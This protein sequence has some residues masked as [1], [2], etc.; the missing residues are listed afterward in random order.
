MVASPPVL[1]VLLLCSDGA[2]H[3]YLAALLG[4]CFGLTA[5]VT[6][7]GDS[8][9]A[10]LRAQ[11]RWR[12]YA[13]SRYHAWRRRV[14]RLDDYRAR[15]FAL[16]AGWSEPQAAE[17][18]TVSSINDPAVAALIGRARPDVTVVMGTSILGRC[19]LAMLGG[20]VIN[21]HGGCLP[22][23]RGNHCFFFAMRDRAW[24]RIGSTLHFVDR[25]IDTGDLIEVVRPPLHAG[26]NAEMLYCRAEKLALHRLAEWLAHVQRGGILPRHAQETRGRLYLTRDRTPLTDVRH[27][28]SVRT[29]RFAV[30]ERAMPLLPP[31]VATEQFAAA[32]RGAAPASAA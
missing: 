32:T 12:D 7:P 23:Y 17:R 19:V 24:D 25:G 29:G 1:R 4:R 26:D 16:P 30:P 18:L 20:T 15:F 14:T 9:V 28:L 22:H 10:R 8:Q 13:A 27:W 21:V 31:I 2:H 3:R 11:G 5:V 6:E